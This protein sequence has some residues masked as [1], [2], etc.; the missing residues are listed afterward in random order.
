MKRPVWRMLVGLWVALA[1]FCGGAAFA[2]A[3]W[4]ELQV[5]AAWGMRTR[6]G[7]TELRVTVT[8]GGAPWQGEL[9]IDNPRE[10]ITY[11]VPLDLPAQTRK[12]YRV[13]VF[14]GDSVSLRLTLRDSKKKRKTSTKPRLYFYS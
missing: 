11:R 14:V 4:P 8:Q 7:W 13:P 12:V 6:A 2:Q 3:A 1:L 9:V 10:A 5:E